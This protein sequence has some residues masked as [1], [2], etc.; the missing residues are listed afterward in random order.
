MRWE[1]KIESRF[2][3]ASNNVGIDMMKKREKKI[4]GIGLW[5]RYH[6]ETNIK[7]E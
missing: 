7:I 6:I 4:F 3:W 5:L 1:L 2:V